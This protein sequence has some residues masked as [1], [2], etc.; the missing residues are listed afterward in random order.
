M[1]CRLTF[2]LDQTLS[3]PRPLINARACEHGRLAC[4]T[5]YIPRGATP[6]SAE[7]GRPARRDT[8]NF[9]MYILNYTCSRENYALSHD[10]SHLIG[11]PIF[12][13]PY[14]E[15]IV[16]LGHILSN[17][18]DDSA[19]IMRATRDMNPKANSLINLY[20]SIFH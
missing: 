1:A 10:S 8:Y 13:Y 19:D 14:S 4:E 15:Q 7:R 16:H 12:S 2:Q 9:I 11:L 20:L 5:I 17:T 18:L 3:F 6:S